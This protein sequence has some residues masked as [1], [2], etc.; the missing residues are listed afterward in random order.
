M[1]EYALRLGYG[2]C[3]RRLSARMGEPAPGRIQ[4]L[5]GPR[6]VG[7]T[8]LLLDLDRQLGEASLYA[9]GDE[10]AA[11]LPGFWERLWV[12][13]ETRASRDKSYLLIDEIQHVPD[14]SQRLKSQWDRVRRHRI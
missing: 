9:A 7:K 5:T 10:P 3:A 1:T 12:E 6:Q 13:A 11:A 4:V 8:T 2:E 14:W